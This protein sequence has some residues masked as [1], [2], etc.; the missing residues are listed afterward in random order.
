MSTATS[1]PPEPR[2]PRAYQTLRFMRDEP[3][4]LEELHARYGDAF[5][6]KVER[7]PWNLLAHPDAIK[8][9]FQAPP[10]VV[11]AGDANE[12]LRN[13]LGRHSVLVLDEG[14]HMRQRKLLLP[15][16]HGDRLRAQRE[17]MERVARAEVERMP[18]GRPFSLRDH[19]Q[20]IALEVILEVVLGVTPAERERHA[21]I[22]KP[23]DRF[24]DWFADP[25]HLWSAVVL[26]PESRFVKRQHARISGPV[27]EQL[28]PLIRDR[29][30]AGDAEERSDVLAMLL[31]AR[32]E[33]GAPMTDAEI[34]DELMTLIVAGHETTATALAW[35]FER[36]TRHG[37][38]LRRLE[39][40]SRTEATQFAE[41]VGKEAMRLRP[42]LMNV[43]R[44]LR[45]PLE[46]GDHRYPAGSVLA[47]SIYLVQRRPELWG[48]DAAEF[49]PTR[50]LEDDVP[51]Y[52]WIPFGGG[53]RR[54][55]GASFALMEMEVVL[56]AIAGTVHLEP[57]G[58]DEP[59]TARF[60][61]ASPAR[62]GQVCASP[63]SSADEDARV[64]IAA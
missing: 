5:R 46:V 12:I 32:D 18:V 59:A 15:A 2:A 58:G 41:A 34:R 7:R 50:F 37:A 45:E 24:L 4:Y 36:L 53:V 56:R 30:A 19:T 22:A 47:P 25:K 61:T 11:H 31:L 23:L 62:G 13:P 52:A 29:R 54:C 6:I 35:A 51:G 55:I 8:Q 63:R 27:D 44:T 64:A 1:L 57:V 28:Y 38:D 39:A 20:E 26:G 33:D 21:A 3:R 48:A 9:V 42:V 10:T 49:R 43:L 60:I 14:E 16:F 40:E 17:T